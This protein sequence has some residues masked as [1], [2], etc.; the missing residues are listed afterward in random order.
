MPRAVAEWQLGHMYRPPGRDSEAD[1]FLSR[2][3]ARVR[4]PHELLTLSLSEGAA[5]WLEAKDVRYRMREMY[6]RSNCP[7]E[8]SKAMFVAATPRR[9]AVAV[10]TDSLGYAIYQSRD[11]SVTSDLI[12]GMDLSVIVWRRTPSGWRIV[13]TYSLLAGAGG[14]VAV[15]C[16]SG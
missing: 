8:V 11:S 15:M 14:A 4:T 1:W 12:S 10:P 13:P 7:S 6:S 9:V 5:R 3:F 16:K 2:E